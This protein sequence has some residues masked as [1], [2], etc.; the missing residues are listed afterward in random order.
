VNLAV[1]LAQ[2]G[3]RVL[4]V[5]ADLHRPRLHEVF[6]V[7]NR[8]GLVSILA[9]NVNPA[10]A[11]VN[12]GVPDVFLV[13]SGPSSP[14]PSG[15]LSSEAMSSFLEYSRTNFDYVIL[16]APPVAAI[17]D[18]LVVGYQTDGIVLC[19]RGGV[20]P[21]DQVARVRDRVVRSNVRILGVLISNLDETAGAYGTLSH[22]ET[23]YGEA[24]GQGEEQSVASAA[25]AG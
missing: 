16:D 15:L 18:A 3:K 2:L 7:S 20:T 13:T 8:T 5:D 1:V 25:R 9:E 22:D 6:H 10:R 17:A 12:S 23:Y 14:N 24:I 4:L 21:R 11:I 19:V